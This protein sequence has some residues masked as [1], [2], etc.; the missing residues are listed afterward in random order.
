MNLLDLIISPAFAEG[1][2]ATISGSGLGD[3]VPLVLLFVVFYFLL[4]R[5]QQKR[6][7]EHKILLTALKKGDEIVTNGGVIGVVKS[8][9]ESFAMLEIANGVIIKVQKQGINQKMPKGSANI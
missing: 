8:V 3:L 2:A 6:A 7:K 5:P 4:I 1:E 9:D